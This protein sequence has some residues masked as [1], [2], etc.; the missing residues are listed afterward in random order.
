[1]E[2]EIVEEWN[3]ELLKRREVFFRLKYKGDGEEGGAS[4]SREEARTVLI[5]ELRC[6]SDLLVIDWMRQE[7]GKRETVGYAKVYEREDRLKAI[8]REHIIER[9]FGAGKE[10]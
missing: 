3:N 6:G 10:E 1:M 2:I 8:E 9:N 5:K 4:P 7:F